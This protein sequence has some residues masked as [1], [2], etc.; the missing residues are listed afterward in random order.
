MTSV[1]FLLTIILQNHFLKIT[2]IK[3]I[4]ANLRSFD[5]ETNSPFQDQRKCLEKSMENMNIGLSV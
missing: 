3:E 1:K 5:G 4:I 2:R